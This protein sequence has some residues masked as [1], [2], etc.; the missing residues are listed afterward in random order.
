MKTVS[1]VFDPEICRWVWMEM[2]EFKAW[3]YLVP[4]LV[5]ASVANAADAPLPEISGITATDR[6]PG[7]CVDCH[8]NR[9]QDSLDVRLSTHA[10][11]WAAG[12]DGKLLTKA[13]VVTR[14]PTSLSGRHPPLAPANFQNVPAQCKGCH[15]GASP[16]VPPLAALM[17]VI[18]LSG[19]KEN[20]FLTIFRGEC[21]H[22]HKFDARSGKWSM[23]TGREK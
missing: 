4:C 2:G 13:K 22:C 15:S 23:P 11:Q 21:T 17:H 7:G 6:F 1:V 10:R 3:L 9:P 18:H 19:G 16:K 12:V 14:D 8:V 5:F 20:H